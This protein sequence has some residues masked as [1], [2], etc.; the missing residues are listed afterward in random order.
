MDKEVKNRLNTTLIRYRVGIFLLTLCFCFAPSGSACAQDNKNSS[1]ISQNDAKE[2]D[3]TARRFITR[4]GQTRDITPLIEEFFVGDFQPF[5]DN[6]Y[7]GTVSPE[8]FS[9][10][11]VSE[12]RRLF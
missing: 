1:I 3:A 10:L 7:E 4:L 2:I 5:L 11:S 12:T 8:L 6:V 9:K